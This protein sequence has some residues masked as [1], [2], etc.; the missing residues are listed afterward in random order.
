MDS[1]H[2]YPSIFALGHRA[3]K[4]ILT[5][6]VLVQE[7]IDGCVTP[8][9]LILTADLRYVPAG[10]LRI[11]DRL[12]A[13]HDGPRNK[14]VAATVTSI[15][16][17]T[18][19]CYNVVTETRKVTASADHPWLRARKANNGKA[20]EMTESL[21]T[22]DSI[23]AF[24]MWEHDR[25][26]EAGCVNGF[27]EGE[28]TI[29]RSE[30][31]RYISAS[32]ISGPTAERFKDLI[33]RV[34]FRLRAVAPRRR[35]DPRTG[36]VNRPGEMLT[37]SGR[38]P[39]ALRFLGT[40]RP[41]RLLAKAER[42]WTNASVGYLPRERVLSVSPVGDREVVGL[43]TSTGTYVAAGMLCHNSQLSFGFFP[44]TDAEPLRARSKGAQLNVLAPEKMFARGIE[45][46]RAL[47]LHEG[48]TYRGE[49]LG[50]P[51]HNALAYDR[52][53]AN[54]VILFDINTGHEEYLPYDAV[55]DEAARLGF[56]VV[57]RL[58]E[59]M[60]A[61]I[62]MFREMLSRTSVLGGQPVEGVVVKNYAL[63]GPDK[64]VLMAKYVSERFKEVHAAEWKLSNPAAGDV[65]QT[66]IQHYRT[67]ARWQKAVQHL[68]EAGA[69]EQ[70]PRDIGLLFKEV[71]VDVKTEC[72]DEI[73]QKLFEWAWPKV[74]RGITAGLAEFY[75]EDLLRQQFEVSE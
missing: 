23:V 12:L 5:T 33:T 55:C 47:P 61:G 44:G 22:G 49:F 25:S 34:G 30:N 67:P 1:Y 19:P 28:G 75:K 13:F 37:I 16:R 53:P 50:K 43:S 32:Q 10:D 14:L 68:R 18:K 59:G 70:S 52:I 58:H 56:E 24:P 72:E 46:I 15:G 62:E 73:K 20:W 51:K 39:E 74:S 65:I 7:K 17:V 31:T 41:E 40:V 29:V 64:K 27:F 63:F 6:P 21:S 71:P 42:W 26:W 35:T 48:W 66:L 45:I 60:V 54:H 38:W 57:P 2:S 11:G 36:H 3:V 69:L 9:T 4:D 8:E